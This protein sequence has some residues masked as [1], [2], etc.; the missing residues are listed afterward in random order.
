MAVSKSVEWDTCAENDCIGVRLPTGGNCWAHATGQHLDAELKRLG[1]QGTLDARGVTISAELL[2]RILKAAPRA[3]RPNRPRFT[4]ASFEDATFGND[5]SFEGVRF[6]DDASFEGVRFGDRVSFEGAGFGNR[7][8]FAGATFGEGAW[9]G[10]A[11][12]GDEAGFAGATFGDEAGF[13]DAT[14]RNS[15]SFEGATFGNQVGFKVKSFGTFAKFCDATFGNDA[16]FEDATF[17]DG[18]DFSSAVFGDGAE[19]YSA[20]FGEGAWFGGATFGDEAGFAGATFGDYADFEGVTFGDLAGLGPLLACGLFRLDHATFGRGPELAVYAD[21]LDCVGMRLTDGG[22]IEARWAEVRLD[23]VDFGRPSVLAGVGPFSELDESPLQARVAR[24]WRT[25]RPRVLSLR[26]S[27]VR[28]L[29][30][31]NVDLRACRFTGAHNLDQLRLEA[32]IDLADRPSG[33]WVGWAL[34]PLWR[35]TRRRTL[36]EEHHW[37]R[38]RPKHAGWYPPACQVR[39]LA[40]PERPLRPADIA[41]LYRALRKGREDAKDEPGAADFYYGEMEM[42]RNA[43]PQFSVDRWILTLYWL[44]SG[45]ALRASRAVFGWM[46]LVLVGAAMFAG[47]GFKPPPS[48]QIVP[49]DVN[50]LGRAVYEKRDIP[51][52]SSWEQVPEALAFSAESTVSLLRAP[53]R[54]LTLPG[55]WV[56]MLPRILG[57]VLFGLFVLSLRGR[58]KR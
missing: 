22:V 17:G 44:F 19:F 32:T 31:S 53:D 49:V 27:D 5:A 43:A 12:F 36:A 58:V 14:F 20:T 48:P 50:S 30:L 28:N 46:L 3:K 1:E 40:E 57:P 56:Q 55:R 39:D 45:Y 52:P 7:V 29:V 24:P 8:S 34:P 54:S 10:G 9:F 15:A 51:R 18:A 26:G 23:G 47:F 2:N 42:R 37:R 21:R 6:G 35:W 13:H 38:T 4:K 11:T 33:L 25:A 16:R 41:L